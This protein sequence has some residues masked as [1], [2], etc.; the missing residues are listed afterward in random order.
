MV[1]VVSEH[2]GSME[3]L[4]TA[5]QW[6][7]GTHNLHMNHPNSSSEGAS[8]SVKEVMSKGSCIDMPS[9]C[10]GCAS[11]CHMKGLYRHQR[12]SKPRFLKT[13]DVMVSCWLNRSPK[14]AVPVLSQVA[15]FD[16]D[17]PLSC[18]LTMPPL[19]KK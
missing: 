3:T 6:P 9:N 15:A 19:L 11:F 5:K 17:V 12:T 14:R 13:W 1:S 18:G 7:S 4:C 2:F 10:G 8:H 16:G